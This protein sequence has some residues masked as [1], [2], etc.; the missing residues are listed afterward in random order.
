M[1]V[2]GTIDMFVIK[3]V[4]TGEDKMTDILKQGLIHSY[5]SN[6]SVG[7]LELIDLYILDS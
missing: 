2:V 4:M 5:Y 6:I 7:V 1:E 3:L